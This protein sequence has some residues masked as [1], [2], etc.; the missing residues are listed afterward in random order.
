[1]FMYRNFK[2]KCANGRMTRDEWRSIFRTAFPYAVNFRFADRL[3]YAISTTRGHSNITFE[4]CANGRMTRD[5][6]RS[7]FRTAF[8]YAV[9]FRFADRLYYAIST[10]RGHSNITFEDLVISLW[11]LTEGAVLSDQQ[12]QSDVS[13]ITAFVFSM[14]EPD[15]KGRVD[16]VRFYDYVQSIFDLCSCTREDSTIAFGSSTANLNK[17]MTGNETYQISPNVRE[18]ASKRFRMLDTDRDGFITI[19]DIERELSSKRGIALMSNHDIEKG[20]NKKTS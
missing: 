8:P 11:E 7:I 18:F 9:N 14:L 10:T 20:S 17:R 6:W 2:Q 4:K 15:P 1:M 12:Q 13:F 19:N 3:Y 5:E 16:E